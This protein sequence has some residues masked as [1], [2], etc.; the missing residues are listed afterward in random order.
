MSENKPA[1]WIKSGAIGCFTMDQILDWILDKCPCLQ[2]AVDLCVQT[3]TPL[4]EL[5]HTGTVTHTHT[6]S[7]EQLYWLNAPLCVAAKPH[8]CM[9]KI[10]YNS[11][12]SCTE[13]SVLFIQ[14]KDYRL[15]LP[16][17]QS[18]GEPLGFHPQP[19]RL[20]RFGRAA[21]PLRL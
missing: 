3:G 13:V 9:S 7:A 20:L 1:N 11:R 19:S 16:L 15:P 8:V 17:L 2:K 18:P 6:H 10:V 5:I 12:Y 14:F 21:L 4:L